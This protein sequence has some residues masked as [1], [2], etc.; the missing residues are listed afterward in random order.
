MGAMW[1][2]EA[3]VTC[4]RALAAAGS[5][6]ATAAQRTPTSACLRTGALAELQLA[7][8]P[9]ESVIHEIPTRTR[10]NQPPCVLRTTVNEAR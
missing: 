3:M 10:R 7:R 5:Q 6:G 4:R 8:R 9:C 2:A 1:Q